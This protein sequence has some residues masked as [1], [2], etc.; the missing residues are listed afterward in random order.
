M[1]KGVSSEDRWSGFQSH[2]Y[3]TLDMFLN[4]SVPVSLLDKMTLIMI[5]TIIIEH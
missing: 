2:V 4:P 5:L 3:V 1:V